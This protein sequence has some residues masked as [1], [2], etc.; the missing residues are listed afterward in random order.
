MKQLEH[1]IWVRHGETEWNAIKK[2]QGQANIGLSELGRRQVGSLVS[3][4]G[5][6]PIDSAVSSDLQRAVQTVH[7]LG[8]PQ[9]HQDARLR[10]ADLGDWTGCMVSQLKAEHGAQYKRWRDGQDKPPQGESF[11]DLKD[12]V[13]QAVAELQ[14]RPGNVLVVAHGG[15]IRAALSLLL[16]LHPD[17]IVAVDPASVTVLNMAATPRLVAYNLCGQLT[18]S[19]TSD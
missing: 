10:E 8:W 18:T 14:S 5:R 15:V 2:L 17:K 6:W 11:A 16:G 19:D 9:A 13:A 7:M 3:V 4:M 1:L 12:R